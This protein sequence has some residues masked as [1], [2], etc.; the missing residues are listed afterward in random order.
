MTDL[1][2]KRP[3]PVELMKAAEPYLTEIGWAEPWRLTQCKRVWQYGSKTYFLYNGGVILA[4]VR[5]T[6]LPIVKRLA[7]YYGYADWT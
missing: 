6:K 4:K 2:S 7:R 1:R 3:L 5:V